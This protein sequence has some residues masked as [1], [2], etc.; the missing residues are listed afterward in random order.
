MVNAFLAVLIDAH[1]FITLHFF[2]IEF[3]SLLYC[4]LTFIILFFTFNTPTQSYLMNYLQVD[5]LSKTYGE[6]LLFKNI[7]FGINQGQKVALIAQ[8]GRG[9]TSLLNIILGKDIADEGNVVIRKG[10][11]IGYLPQKMEFNA[12]STVLEAVLDGNNAFFDTVKEYEEALQ[13]MHSDHSETTKN[14][15][16]K[17]AERMD[18]LGAWD[19]EN[20]IKEILSRL[21]INDLDLKIETLSGGQKRKIAL[22]KCLIEEVDLLILDEPTNHLDIDMIEWLEEFINTQKMTLLVVTHDRYFLD[23]VCQEILELDQ[24]EIYHYRG[25]Y[26]YF[27]EKKAERLYNQAA[28]QEKAR[29][30]YRRE[31]EWM[32]RMPKARTTKSKARIDAFYDLENKA[33]KTT[34]SEMPDFDVKISRI[35]NKILEVNHI[36]KAYGDLNLIQDFSHTFLRGERIGIVGAN[37]SGKTTFFKLI[38]GEAKPDKGHIVKGQTMVFGYF[39]Q[40]GLKVDENKRLIDLVK[41]VAEEIPFGSSSTL[42]AAQFLHY[43]NFDYSTQHN[44]YRNL[45]GGEKQ[46]LQLLLTFVNNPNFLILDEPTN[47]LDIDTLSVLEEFLVKYQGCLMVTSHDRAFL[48]RV[49]DHIFVFEE[50]GKI[51]DYH[52]NYSEYR[53]LKREQE[54]EAKRQKQADK[55]VDIQIEKPKVQKVTFNQKREF[56]LLTQEMEKLETEKVELL[57]KLNAGTGS[58]GDFTIWSA[59]FQEIVNSLD[60][61][62]LRWLELSEIMG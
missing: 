60:D 37:G 32:R 62:E 24:E 33:R 58:A 13:Q 48:D 49:A 44:Y 51:K 31:L 40:D 15:L 43:F 36:H 9:K 21:K 45:S 57:N 42:S 16:Q 5:N 55:Q 50:N 10:V 47:D 56:E 22:A 61:K 8:N 3:N 1:K 29:N 52:S 19:Y 17:A 46:R 54:K 39:A 41:D 35:G 18:L 30:L 6:K 38:M 4:Y 27:V 2:R 7:S 34:N 28:E 59:R 14:R 53:N 25:K 12:L 11:K 20:R 26:D 23:Q